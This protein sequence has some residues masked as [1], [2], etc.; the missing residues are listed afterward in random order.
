MNHVG[1]QFRSARFTCIY[2][3]LT[4]KTSFV[5]Y[6]VSLLQV[7]FKL[8][9]CAKSSMKRSFWTFIPSQL[10]FDH[11]LI[12]TTKDIILAYCRVRCCCAAG[13]VAHHAS[14]DTFKILFFIIVIVFNRSY[15]EFY[16]TKKKWFCACC[17]VIFSDFPIFSF[18][19]KN[20]TFPK[21]FLTFFLINRIDKFIKI[22]MGV[23]F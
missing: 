6:S 7:G 16:P 14:K 1:F 11:C 15:I 21:K 2:F 4:G 12:S 10:I 22:L 8:S 13:D 20:R 5:S 3:H 18:H 19:G 23:K 9:V 17:D